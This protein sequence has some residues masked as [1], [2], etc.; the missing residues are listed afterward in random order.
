MIEKR[1]YLLFIISEEN[2]HIIKHEGIVGFKERFLKSLKNL[3]KGDEVIVYIKGKKLMG[4]FNLNSLLFKD[5]KKIFPDEIYPLRFKIKKKGK[6]KR[7]IFVDE[8]IP[9]LDFITNKK[10]WMG[11]FQG[12]SFI[13]LSRKDFKLLE[14][15]LNEK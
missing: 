4:I 5:E 1:K 3:S 2:V 14:N 12:K 9:K 13:V 7:K 11:N 8:L 6:I 10:H 15:Y